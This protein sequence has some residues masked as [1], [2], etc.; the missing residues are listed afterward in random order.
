M[1]AL[2]IQTLLDTQARRLKPSGLRV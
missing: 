2:G 1:A